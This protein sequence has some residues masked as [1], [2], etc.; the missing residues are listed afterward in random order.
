MKLVADFHIQGL[1]ATVNQLAY[2]H[3]RYRHKEATRWKSLV[4]Q[5]CLV[6]RIQGLNLAKAQIE[7]TRVSARECDFD[8]LAGSFK[9]VLD[10]LKAAQVIVDDRPSVIGSPTFIWEKGKQKDGKIRIRI[11]SDL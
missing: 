10:G 7:L 1:P 9:H 5:L 4:Y 6:N 8:N 2:K 11:W 3:W